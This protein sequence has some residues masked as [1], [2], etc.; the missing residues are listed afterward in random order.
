MIKLDKDEGRKLIEKRVSEISKTTICNLWN[1]Y[2][3]ELTN[4]VRTTKT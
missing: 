2:F 3:K 4:I 1:C